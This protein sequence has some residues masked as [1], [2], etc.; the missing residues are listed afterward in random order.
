MKIGVFDS[1]IGGLTVLDEI[2]KLLP[3]E[4]YIYVADRFHVPYGTKSKEAVHGYVETVAE[5]LD[6][7]G[8]DAMVVA[9]NTATSISVRKLRSHY[10]FPVIGMEPAVKPAINLSVEGKIMVMATPLTLAEEKYHNLIKKYDAK[11]QV[12][13]QEMAR[14]VDYAEAADYESLEVEAYIRNQLSSYDLEDFDAIVLGCTHF[15]YF[16]ALLRGLVPKH[17]QIIDGNL[18]TAKHLKHVMAD[19]SSN[20]EGSVTCYETSANGF[21]AL[22]RSIYDT[23]NR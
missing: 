8:V 18:G 11:T 19:K 9:C 17:I 16:K 21:V 10:E 3:N 2:K 23:N 6:S 20:V 5:F 7:K 22:D 15:I 13:S 14:L 1:G 12:V 4:Q